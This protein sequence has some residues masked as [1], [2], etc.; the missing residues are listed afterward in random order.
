MSPALNKPKLS[1]DLGG[2]NAT[3][4]LGPV[5]WPA[6]PFCSRLTFPALIPMVAF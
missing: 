2:A 6:W 5:N 3:G 1:N 4:P